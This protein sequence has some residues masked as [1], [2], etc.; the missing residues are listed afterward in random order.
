[1]KTKT[2]ATTTTLTTTKIITLTTKTTTMTTMTTRIPRF[3]EKGRKLTLW[4]WK[5]YFNNFM[6]EVT[7]NSL[8]C[9]ENPLYKES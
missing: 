6:H 3:F 8:D 7:N 2:T 9:K 1:M 5:M 4:N